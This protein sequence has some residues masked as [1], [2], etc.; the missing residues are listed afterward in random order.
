VKIHR[1]K[2]MKK[3]GAQ[4]LADLVRMAGILDLRHTKAPES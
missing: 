4:S 1:G 2:L 3:M